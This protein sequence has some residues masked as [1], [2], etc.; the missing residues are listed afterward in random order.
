MQLQQK[1]CTDIFK[2]VQAEYDQEGVAWTHVDFQ[3]RF[4]SKM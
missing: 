2:G 3:V 4:T 1:F